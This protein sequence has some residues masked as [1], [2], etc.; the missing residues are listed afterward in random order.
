MLADWL[1]KSY[2]V[3]AP[4]PRTYPVARAIF[5]QEFDV[6]LLDG[7]SLAEQ[8]NLV[9]LLREKE[10][11]IFAP[12]LLI[13]SRE[14]V[15]LATE[16]LWR[17]IDDVVLKPV[18]K[19]ELNARIAILLRARHYS[20]KLQERYYSLAEIAPVGILVIGRHGTV[21]YANEHAHRIF[22]ERGSRLVGRSLEEPWDF[23]HPAGH[24]LPREEWPF[25]RIVVSG[26]PVHDCEMAYIGPS[27]SELRLSI[28]GVPAA[29]ADGVVGSV[30]LV[31]KDITAQVKRAEELRLARD[32]AEEMSRLKS[33]FLANMSHEIRTPLTGI[34]S[35]AEILSDETDG[36]LQ[37]IADLITISAERLRRTLSAVLDLAELESNTWRFS[38]TC[39]ELTDIVSK[40]VAEQRSMAEERN[41]SIFVD[42]PSSCSVQYDGEALGHIIESLVSNA[43]KFTRD[44]SVRVRIDGREDAVVVEVRDDGIG[45]SRDFLPHIFEEF[46]QESDGVARNFEGSG[47]GLTIAKRLIML[48]GGDIEVESTKGE[49]STF[50]VVLPAATPERDE[51]KE[52]RK[53]LHVPSDG[54]QMLPESADAYFRIFERHPFPCIILDAHALTIRQ[55]NAAV[56]FYGYSSDDLAGT[57]FSDFCIADD[58]IQQAGDHETGWGRWNVRGR[59]GTLRTVLAIFYAMQSGGGRLIV[60]HLLDDEPVPDTNFVRAE[61]LRQLQILQS[62]SSRIA[63]VKDLPALY[64]TVKESMQ[65]A[66]EDVEAFALWAY[67]RD[68]DRITL[69]AAS[70]PRDH[71]ELIAFSEFPE[72]RSLLTLEEIR[73]E[74]AAEGGISE[75]F[76]GSRTFAHAQSVVVIPLRAGGRPMAI[77]VLASARAKDPARFIEQRMMQAFATLG[78]MVIQRLRLIERLRQASRLLVAAQESER[79][80]ISQDMHDEIGGLLSSLQLLLK[81][82]ASDDPSVLKDLQDATEIVDQLVGHIRDVSFRLS[83]RML[84]DLGLVPT[85]QSYTNRF[86]AR[87]RI[88]VTLQNEVDSE[89]RFEHDVESTAFRLVQ[90]SLTNVAKYAEAKTVQIHLRIDAGSLFIHVIDDGK[91]FDAEDITARLGGTGLHGLSERVDLIGG[92]FEIISSP[93]EGTRI[94]AV[95]PLSRALAEGGRE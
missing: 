79:R 78:G 42:S 1:G 22:V 69:A 43:V 31:V 27:G 84:T 39:T 54:A 77:M 35:S 36:E 88:D 62:F 52:T 19:A 8:R 68:N 59:D 49:G 95:L 67:N 40:V 80:A 15:N 34:L 82:V 51:S 45:I 83:P 61:R 37:E 2:T 55:T 63:T 65:E 38:D 48:L 74:Y 32:R 47:L 94:S 50:R 53:E 18:G 93:G 3:E 71:D 41:V 85:L 90:E 21:R 92:Q 16:D 57:R 58:S 75:P 89:V 20:I 73:V 28:S 4:D 64:R 72:L 76:A 30:L 9:R 29:S 60:V 12:L 81:M 46:K 14:S 66:F 24:R 6:V 13:T 44:G 87:T 11:D 7:P 17:L 26:E 70:G 56:R 5:E 91:G 33:S 86:A 25:T 23:M 10:T